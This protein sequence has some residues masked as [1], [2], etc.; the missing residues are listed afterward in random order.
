MHI[1]VL[2]IQLI[3][4]NENREKGLCGRPTVLKH[5]KRL[6]NDNETNM[7]N[8]A[9]LCTRAYN[10]GIRVLFLAGLLSFNSISAADTEEIPELDCVIEPSEVADL[11]SAVSGVIGKIHAKRSDTIRKGDIVAEL[12][13]T[14]ERANVVLSKARAE[15]ETSIDLREQ[16]AAFGRRTAERNQTLYQKASISKQDIDKLNTENRI[17]QLQVHQEQDNKKIA[18][19]EYERA[20]AVLNRHLIRTPFD[21]VV[22]ERFKSVGE[23]I[24]DDPVVRVAQL[25][26]LHV[27]VLLPVEYMGLLTPGRLAEVTPNLPGFAGQ[28]ATVTRVDRVADAASDTFGARLSLA[29]P[30]NKVPAGLRC[31]LAF[32]PPEAIADPIAD[33][34]EDEEDEIFMLS[35]DNPVADDPLASAKDSSDPQTAELPQDIAELPQDI[36]ELP[37]DMVDQP[38]NT[39]QTPSTPATT[40]DVEELVEL[41]DTPEIESTQIQAQEELAGDFVA[42]EVNVAFNMAY[43]PD[44]FNDM[45]YST[46]CYRVGPLAN[47]ALA[48]ELSDTMTAM[49]NTSQ[50]MVSIVKSHRET[51]YRVLAAIQPNL[52]ATDDLAG[53][54]ANKGVEDIYTLGYG[55]LKGRTSLGLYGDVLNALSREENLRA[56]GVAAEILEINRELSTYWINLSFDSS[57]NSQLEL[58]TVATDLAPEASVQLT[59]CNQQQVTGL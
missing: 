51:E 9:W 26:P 53:Y 6:F 13:S 7:K 11:G 24:E 41:H 19:L 20:K 15:L 5:Q 23:F 36:V 22:M 39:N 52:L 27:E 49:D 35:D 12:D 55:E 31:R 34:E 21:G 47:A 58:Q 8:L 37:Q 38:Q 43:S 57:P 54:L 4:V 33:D 42:S 46:A 30:D 45:A 1:G 40:P 44:T 50:P 59:Q 17:A 28:V 18:K 16:S 32:L 14:V 29:N 10:L 2:L 25:D 48:S 3:R 56:M